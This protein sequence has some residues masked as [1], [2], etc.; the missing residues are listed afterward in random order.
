[1]AMNTDAFIKGYLQPSIDGLDRQ[2]TLPLPEEENFEKNAEFILQSHCPP[3]YSTNVIASYDN[4]ASGVRLVEVY[5]SSQNMNSG[6]FVR[7]VGTMAVVKQGHPFLF[8]DAAV[9]NID[10]R[11]GER[12]EPATRIAVHLPQADGQGRARLM[13]GLTRQ[14]EQAGLDCGTMTIDALPPFWGPL[15]HVRRPGVDLDAIERVRGFA[16]D[17][18]TE[19]CGASAGDAA[20]DYLPVQIQM[21]V[22]NSR[23]EQGQFQRMGLD[24]PAEVQAA[25]FSLLCTGI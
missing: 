2:F 24:V 4:T 25:F 18:Y 17:G 14:A 22:K 9:S 8:L 5:K 23:A 16:W 11:T 15:W 20:F 10:M 19:Y 6:A 13:Q 12:A 3:T 21:I 1:M 7:L